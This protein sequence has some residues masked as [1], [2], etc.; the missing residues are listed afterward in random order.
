MLWLSLILDISKKKPFQV[1]FFPISFHR[2]SKPG[3]FPFI[4]CSI[5][6]ATVRGMILGYFWWYFHER[7]QYLPALYL[8]RPRRGPQPGS[9]GEVQAVLPGD[10]HPAWEHLCPSQKWYNGDQLRRFAKNDSFQTIIPVCICLSL[11]RWV[12]SCLVCLHVQATLS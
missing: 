1:S 4:L 2:I 11:V 8:G 12:P 10:R 9:A 7:C 3:I 6:S 5:S